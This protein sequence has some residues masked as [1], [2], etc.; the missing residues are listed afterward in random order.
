MRANDTLAGTVM[1]IAAG[2]M[3]YLTLDFPPFP[4][5]KY[6]PSLFPRILGTG[7]VLCG[8]LLIARGLI[9]KRREPM[10][11]LAGWTQNAEQ[12]QSFLLVVGLIVAYIL[13]SEQIGFLIVAFVLLTIL[14]LWFRARPMLALPVAAIATWTIHYFFSSLMRVPLPRGIL[15]NIL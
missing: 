3:I 11:R 10:L 7:L 5:Q 6:G 14:F 12:L 15:T 4:G 13:V 1:I 8:L 2:V 9:A